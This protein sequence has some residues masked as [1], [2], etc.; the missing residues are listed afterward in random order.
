MNQREIAT[1]L[2]VSQTSVSLV[3]NN[4]QTKKLSADKRNKILRFLEKHDYFAQAGNGKTRNIA[5]LFPEQ[6]AGGSHQ[7]F[8]D[9]FIMGIEAE[10][11]QVGYNVIVERYKK[12]NTLILP[13]KKIDGVILEGAIN[14]ENLRSIAEKTPTVLLNNSVCEPICDMV[15][16]DNCGGIELALSYLIN[17][18]HSKIAYFAATINNTYFINNF[19]RRIE[20]FKS[21]VSALNLVQNN[22]YIQLPELT[23]A[24][25]E[26][27]DL[28]I[29]ETLKL[30]KQMKEPPTAVLCYNDLYGLQMIR[31]ANILG[32][33]VPQ[34]L[35]I[36]GMDNI[37]GG[38]LSFPSLTTIDHN[39]EE[40]GRLSVETLIQRID[41]PERVF[42]KISS[43]ACLVCRESVVDLNK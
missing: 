12:N 20:T 42:H 4:P 2:G 34:E 28:K 38:E 30:W 29:S 5:Y 23:K 40:M 14:I 16:P 22:D 27:T 3:L 11:S 32:I 8:Y 36:I 24:T 25:L 33:K 6:P 18:G 15:Y 41:H 19:Y 17:R 21:M 43:N 10:A 9:R 35:S 37:P 1:A 13:Q 26:E 39:A 7:R 31:Q